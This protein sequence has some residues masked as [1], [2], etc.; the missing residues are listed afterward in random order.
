[1]G[2]RP[3]AGGS[4]MVVPHSTRRPLISGA[5]LV[6]LVLLAAAAAAPVVAA[7]PGKGSAGTSYRFTYSWR[8]ESHTL[9]PHS[10]YTE[11]GSASH[12][13]FVLS[14]AN[15]TGV[16]ATLSWR[17][18]I[19]APDNLTL[20][21]RSPGGA[22]FGPEAGSGGEGRIDLDAP[23]GS[24]PTGEVVIEAATEAEA[25]AQFLQAYP[26]DPLETGEW[27]ATVSVTDA[28]DLHVADVVTQPD[29]GNNWTLS[30]TYRTY[31][32]VLLKKEKVTEETP[33]PTCPGSPG[34]P[35]VNNGTGNN[36]T[37]KP[38]TGAPRSP[39]SGGGL[40]VGS[41][42]TPMQ[43]VAGVGA[44]VLGVGVALLVARKRDGP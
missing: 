28:G 9:S 24:V 13:A 7:A 2:L 23:V 29:P 15:L 4:A 25:W 44:A 30:V 31:G 26:A 10:G 38:A 18:A 3:L 40:G 21:A 1:M 6:V 43:I 5:C 32:G 42:A 37:K 34:C 14:R 16:V 33:T 35:P 12:V 8:I 22:A 39:G 17:D 27:N 41:I 11:E 19:G 36:E 20:E